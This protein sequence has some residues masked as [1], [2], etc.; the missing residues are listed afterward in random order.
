MAA[1]CG[2]GSST[3]GEESKTAEQIADDAQ[4]AAETARAVHVTGSVAQSVGRLTVDM[5]LVKDAGA[6]GTISLRGGKVG[7]VRVGSKVYMKGNGAFWRAIGGEAAAQLLK[8]RWVRVPAG[9]RGLDAIIRFTDIDQ[10]IAGTV[11]AHGKVSKKGR[12][13]YKGHKVIVLED[14]G[15]SGGTIYVANTGTPYPVAIVSPNGG[16]EGSLSY[17]DWN[18]VVKIAAPKDAIDLNKVQTGS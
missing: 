2:G 7:L 9:Q 10:L 16:A 17:G 6:K 8:G 1:G 14:S 12:K 5:R 13:D 4:Q 18:E 11:G 15:G 3:N